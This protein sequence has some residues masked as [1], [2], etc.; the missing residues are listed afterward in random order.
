MNSIVSYIDKNGYCTFN[1]GTATVDDVP[2][3]EGNLILE[4]YKEHGLYIAIEYIDCGD[5]P[6]EEPQ[7]ICSSTSLDELLETLKEMGYDIECNN[8]FESECDYDG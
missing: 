2:Y 7:E 5:G 3:R 6:V 4:I 8:G 1:L